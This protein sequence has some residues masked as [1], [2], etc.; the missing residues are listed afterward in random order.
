[1]S[2]VLR[3]GDEKTVVLLDKTIVL[4]NDGAWKLV[5]FGSLEGCFAFEVWWRMVASVASPSGNAVAI[6]VSPL[7]LF[8]SS[9]KAAL[10]DAATTEMWRRVSTSSLTDQQNAARYVDPS[11]S[12]P[13]GRSWRVEVRDNVSATVGNARFLVLGRRQ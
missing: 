11:L 5:G 13:N 4:A 7:E 1:M 8:D 3:A 10:G 6:F 9:V 2:S 12:T